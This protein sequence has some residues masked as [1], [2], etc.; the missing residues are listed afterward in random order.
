MALNLD[1]IAKFAES[2]MV[3]ECVIRRYGRLE[4]SQ[5]AGRN[6][7]TGKYDAPRVSEEIMYE[8]KCMIYSKAVDANPTMEGGNEIAIQQRFASLPREV[9]WELLP[10]DELEITDIN[11]DGDQSL[12]GVK[13][14]L[15]AVDQGTYIAS[16]DLALIDRSRTQRT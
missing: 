12:L 10:E 5:V 11:P 13:Y 15:K 8:G 7:T 16:R 1:P 6:E 3:D 14:L 2:L 9:D 4:N